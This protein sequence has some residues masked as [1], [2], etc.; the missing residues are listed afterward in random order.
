MFIPEKYHLPDLI[1]LLSKESKMCCNTCKHSHRRL[2]CY[3]HWRNH[4]PL[5]AQETLYPISIWNIMLWTS[6]DVSQLHQSQYTGLTVFP[7]YK[8]RFTMEAVLTLHVENQDAVTH[9]KRGS[10]LYLPTLV[11]VSIF[12]VNIQ[13]G[14]CNNFILFATGHHL[15][16][17]FSFPLFLVYDRLQSKCIQVGYHL[18]ATAWQRLSDHCPSFLSIQAH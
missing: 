14:S 16:I 1:I 8:M 3:T 5:M 2:R 12:A 9:F 10:M 13:S 17:L 7:W 6:E 4:S 11:S 18:W 15:F